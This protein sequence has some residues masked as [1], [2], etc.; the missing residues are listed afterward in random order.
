MELGTALIVVAY[1]R[2]KVS[3]WFKNYKLRGAVEL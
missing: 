3:N 2:G 1:S